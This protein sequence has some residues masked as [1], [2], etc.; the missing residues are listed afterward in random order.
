MT[1]VKKFVVKDL[2]AKV[3]LDFRDLYDLKLLQILSSFRVVFQLVQ[4]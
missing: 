4:V 1:A 3:F 2:A